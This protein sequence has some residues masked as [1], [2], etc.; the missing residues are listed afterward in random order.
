M[1]SYIFR[2]IYR[3]RNSWNRGAQERKVIRLITLRVPPAHDELDPREQLGRRPKQ[4]RGSGSSQGSGDSRD[5]E[6]SRDSG[7]ISSRGSSSRGVNSKA[8]TKGRVYV[9]V[10]K[11]SLKKADETVTLAA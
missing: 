2:R 6:D 11:E 9:T 5:S 3:H 4:R 10:S 1:A 8:E 7:G